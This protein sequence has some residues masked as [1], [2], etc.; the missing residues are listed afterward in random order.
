SHDDSLTVHA[1]L[2]HILYPDRLKGARSHMQGH[3]RRIDPQR[4]YALQQRLVEMQPGGGSSNSAW[5]PVEH[6]LITLAVG[7]L[8]LALDVRWQGDVPVDFQLP[9]QVWRREAEVVELPLAPQNLCNQRL[10]RL[11]LEQQARAGLRRLARPHLG[12][13]LTV[14]QHPLDQ[15][16]DAPPALLAPQQTCRNHPGVVEHQQVLRG[17]E[18]RQIGEMA[19]LHAAVLSR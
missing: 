7:Q 5:M 3:V 16:L 13:C 19:M 14:A 18:L 6:G 1:M 2:E 8:I 17:Q 4:T 10:S 12:Q 9:G 11:S 15:R